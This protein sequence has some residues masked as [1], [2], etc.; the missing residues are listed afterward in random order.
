MTATAVHSTVIFR[1]DKQRRRGDGKDKPTGIFS[2]IGG[3]ENGA[4]TAGVT[5]I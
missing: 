4:T 1:A 2:D 5:H 3:A